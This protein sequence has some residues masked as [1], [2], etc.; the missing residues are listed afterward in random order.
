MFLSVWNYLRGYVTIEVSG[1]SVERFMNLASHKGIYLWDIQRN[2]AKV[3]MKVSIAG[4]RLLKSCAKKTR[5]K[6]RI[7][8]KK[9][10]P[11]ILYRYRKRKVMG[12]GFLIFFGILYILSSFVWVV[13]IKGNTRISTEELTKA[14]GEYGVKPGVWKYKINPSNI[15]GLLMND[16]NDIAWTA[17]D[18]KGTKV[19]V[20]LTETVVKPE[21]VDQT[22]PCDLVA[23]KTGLIVSIATRA[24]TPKVKPKDV[25][26]KGD[27]LVSGELI[28]KQD[29]EGTVIKY[30]HA[31][32]EVKAKTRYEITYDQPL[33]YIEKQYTG[34]VK[35]QYGINILDKKLNLFKPRISFQNYDKIISSR[36]LSVT[37]HFV[38]P[39]EGIIYEYREF[40][41]VTHKRTLEE[42]KKLAEEEIKK[43]LIAQMDEE[44]EIISHDIQFYPYEEFL[45]AKA[46]AIVI[47]RI[48]KPQVIDRRKIINGTKGKNTADTN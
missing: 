30:V 14:L 12:L 9:G 39:I 18:I 10:W 25:V 7:I 28:V 19:T 34:E 16:F 47:E 33:S 11:F 8:E 37:K 36:Q 1:F 5:C 29:E 20:E 15:E 4:F 41:P 42:A 24:G 46:V 2:R 35:K 13:E 31:D 22:T 38:L 21:I 17:V 43:R 48:D 6:V 23:E 3:Q 45:R 26:Q 27:L 40:I 44:S 32:A